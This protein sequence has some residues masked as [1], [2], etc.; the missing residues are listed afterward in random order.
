MVSVMKIDANEIEQQAMEAC[1]AGDAQRGSAL[2][3]RFLEELKESMRAGEDFCPCPAE[4]SL[5]KNCVLCVQVHR[6]HGN[7]LPYCMHRIVNERIKGLSELTEHSIVDEI[8]KP[9]HLK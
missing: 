8:K 5:H 4:C 3:D 2:Q 1:L 7:H 6:G 9:D